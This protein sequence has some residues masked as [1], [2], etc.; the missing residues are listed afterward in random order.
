MGS[1]YAGKDNALGKANVSYIEGTNTL[2]VDLSDPNAQ[3]DI[4]RNRIT[5]TKRKKVFLKFVL[6]MFYTQLICLI[7][8][9]K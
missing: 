9:H 3:D 7:L 8:E 5:L 2:G 6:K 4:V 1:R